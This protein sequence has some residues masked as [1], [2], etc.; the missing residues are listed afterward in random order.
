VP[1]C[2]AE[3]VNLVVNLLRITEFDPRGITL[4]AKQISDISRL[5]EP[6]LFLR[7]FSVDGAIYR[8]LDQC[9]I[10]GDR[11]LDI[12]KINRGKLGSELETSTAYLVFEY[13]SMFIEY[14]EVSVMFFDSIATRSSHRQSGTA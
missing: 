6:V 3:G 13:F 10:V 14:L 4:G 2:A 11:F 1:K 7:S 5:A 9:S 8:E 12:F